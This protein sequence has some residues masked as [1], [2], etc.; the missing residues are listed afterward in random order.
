MEYCTIDN[1]VPVIYE[2]VSKEL[3]SP[4]H[5]KALLH[6]LEQRPPWLPRFLRFLGFQALYDSYIYSSERLDNISIIFRQSLSPLS[7]Y[8]ISER[9]APSRV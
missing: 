3:T 2:Q 7:F 1:G 4:R 6:P 9:F 8:M 5:R